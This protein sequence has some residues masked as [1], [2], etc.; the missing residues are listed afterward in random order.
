MLVKG[1]GASK[2]IAPS[3]CFE[4][5][6]FLFLKKFSMSNRRCSK[7][8]REIVTAYALCCLM[9]GVDS[10]KAFCKKSGAQLSFGSVKL[11]S[12]FF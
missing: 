5:N 8:N 11:Q 4:N 12:I 9:V 3:Q 10:E 7:R 2:H 1:Y 6:T